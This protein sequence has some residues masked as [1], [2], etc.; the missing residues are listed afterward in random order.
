MITG[1]RGRKA[2]G[3]FQDFFEFFDHCLQYFRNEMGDDSSNEDA[4]CTKYV[5]PLYWSILSIA[6]LLT[7]DL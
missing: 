5:I 7:I 1:V 4:I 3:C 6:S 2:L